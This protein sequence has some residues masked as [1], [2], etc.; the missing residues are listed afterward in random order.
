MSKP[1]SSIDRPLALRLRPDLVA[2]P[3]EM[4]GATTWVVKDP[5]T[6]EHFQFSAEEYALMDWLRQPVSIA[7]LQRLFGRTFPPQTI[8]PQAVWDFL[9]RLHDAGLVI[10]DA[11]GP[12]PRAAGPHAPR[13]NSALGDGV[14]GT[15]GDP[16]SR[17]RSGR[18]SHR[19]S[20][21]NPLVVFAGGAVAGDCSVAVRVVA[22]HRPFRRVSAAAAGALARWSIREICPGCCWR[23]AR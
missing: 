22:R 7:E 4:S 16:L 6:L 13:A 19:G 1:L 23:S 8:S 10:S 5:L 9:S 2:A 17:H 21:T 12:R 18:F 11:T 3:V 20:R 14:D 15:L